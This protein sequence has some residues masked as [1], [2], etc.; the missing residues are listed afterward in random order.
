MANLLDAF[1]L[2]AASVLGADPPDAGSTDAGIARV[3]E[4]AFANTPAPGMRVAAKLLL[5]AQDLESRAGPY[6]DEH[7]GGTADI[8]LVSSWDEIAAKL[9]EY[10]RVSD[11]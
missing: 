3:R 11:L 10:E 6:N 2:I 7:L 5:V 8:A 4:K 1:A 9:A